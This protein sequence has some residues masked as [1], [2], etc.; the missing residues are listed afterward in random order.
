MGLYQNLTLV[1]GANART[2]DEEREFLWRE[3]TALAEQLAMTRRETEKGIARQR[4]GEMQA[5][6]D[7]E[8]ARL[9]LLASL[10]ETEGK[11]RRTVIQTLQ[12]DVANVRDNYTRLNRT[13]DERAAQVVR[14]ALVK[15]GGFGSGAWGVLLGGQQ[16]G[17][18]LMTGEEPYLPE[19]LRLAEGSF[20]PF[21]DSPYAYDV[22]STAA[23]R[24]GI[25]RAAEI[26]G[27]VDTAK[28]ELEAVLE[29]YKEERIEPTEMLERAQA[30]A[31]QME[32]PQEEG[33][34]S[35]TAETEVAL[36]GDEV[37]QDMKRRYEE[38]QGVSGSS[39][40][41]T[42]EAM[43]SLV[44]SSRDED[45]KTP[46][47]K[48]AESNGYKLGE[49]RLD[50]EGKVIGYLPGKDDVRALYGAYRQARRPADSLLRRS[51]REWVQV[52]V[53]KDPAEDAKYNDDGFYY[54]IV[55]K[56]GEKVYLTPEEAVDYTG[57]TGQE[58]FVVEGTPV[59]EG[60]QGYQVYSSK[61][62]PK[63]NTFFVYGK[64]VRQHISDPEDSL[65]VLTGSGERLFTKDEIVSKETTKR[66]ATAG[67]VLR[68]TAN[69]ALGRAAE[70]TSR[71]GAE[72]PV[73]EREPKTDLLEG[74]GE[75]IEPSS[76][77]IEQRRR[78][79]A[80]D[81]LSKQQERAEA[82]PEP[83][84]ETGARMREE[85]ATVRQA[86]R[87]AVTRTEALPPGP[88]EGRTTEELVP[89]PPLSPSR[90]PAEQRAADAAATR[91][92]EAR[93]YEDR[94]KAAPS[95][96]PGAPS[97]AITRSP[98]YREAR[99]QELLRLA[100]EFRKAAGEEPVSPLPSSLEVPEARSEQLYQPGPRTSPPPVT[101]TVI[102]GE[103]AIEPQVT[104]TGK[105]VP[106]E[107]P[108]L[109]ARRK[110]YLYTY[111]G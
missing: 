102:P 26:Q 21:A 18:G 50:T 81:I 52:E 51:T 28:A 34:V 43:G 53:K 31:R 73:E 29:D 38:L 83:K 2:T 40:A 61:E 91:A 67:E 59:P 1:A 48:W 72:L 46:F 111:G 107:P 103:S 86:R 98:T 15:A 99:E 24:K 30:A 6:T 105:P 37:F 97:T 16:V 84:T 22:D 78:K 88:E 58:D 27:K 94:D 79:R 55:G 23:M 85:A 42:M 71:A 62:L 45:A 64:R 5:R 49:A 19:I 20:G 17:P 82:K 60:F 8:A 9:R 74:A 92:E 35:V 54:F 13:W 106:G 10:A 36:A 110:R 66:T 77:D 4:L 100:A 32:M 14:Q 41:E 80:L 96:T 75:D 57:Q 65:R 56:D 93:W 3:R 25:A 70:S 11:D 104:P 12:K 68:D 33:A 44:G 89:L 7:Y 39:Q 101:G 69:R 87:E 63:G 109:E 108:S 47:R 95:V 90:G 76:V